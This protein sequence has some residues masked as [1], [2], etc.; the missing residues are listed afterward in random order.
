MPFPGYIYLIIC[1]VMYSPLVLQGQNTP[2]NSTIQ[3][4]NQQR[5]PKQSFMLAYNTRYN[6]KARQG[7]YQ[8]ACPK[9]H[10]ID[11]LALCKQPNQ[12]A[13]RDIR[14]EKDFICNFFIKI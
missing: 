3:K 13:A 7:I 5:Y 10:F 4:S 8:P 9:K 1:Q 14:D 11:I 6:E 2:Y 12:C